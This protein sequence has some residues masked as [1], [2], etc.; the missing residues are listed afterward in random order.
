MSVW[1]D[2]VIELREDI[3]GERRDIGNEILNM[4]SDSGSI[5]LADV[6]KHPIFRGVHFRNIDAAV[7]R[8]EKQGRIKKTKTRQGLTLTLSEEA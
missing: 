8:L 2:E 7:R 4:V 6:A 3:L 1:M 5:E